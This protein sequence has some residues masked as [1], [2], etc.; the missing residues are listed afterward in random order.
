MSGLMV[1]ETNRFLSRRITRFF[2]LVLALLFI[3][4][5]VIA[6]FIIQAQDATVDF[7]GDLGSFGRAAAQGPT[8]AVD[9]PDHATAILGPLG[10][11]LPIMA[12]TLGASFYGADQK[13]GVIELL[14][15]WQPRRLK[16][17][18]TRAIGGGVV[19][20]LIAIVLSAFFVAVMWGLASVAGTTDGMTG[21]MWGW[22]ATS[23]LRSGVA[24]GLFFLLG[25]GLTVLVNN[26]M[27]SIIVFMIYAFVVENLLQ[28]FVG[29]L[30][31]W[32][33]MTNAASF[34]SGTNVLLIDI[35]SDDPPTIQ[36]GYLMAGLI[37]LVYA[38]GAL[39]SGF[40][41]FQRRDVV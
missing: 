5:A 30:A 23:V 27:A 19:T 20:T 25:L 4:G 18:S 37:T 34:V 40:V 29:W 41:I 32:L 17:L 7:V 15:T 14:L 13:S 10:F 38:L 21:E 22:I 28:A 6:Y 16:F 9:Q 39:A 33:P 8:G 3:V 2:P 26:S 31:P 24:A 36:H 12:F 1:A 35:F 11:L